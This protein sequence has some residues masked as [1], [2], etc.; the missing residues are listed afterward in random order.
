MYAFI[1]EKA[2][3]IGLR[4]G[5]YG[6]RNTSL[7]SVCNVNVNMDRLVITEGLTRFLNG[8]T[9]FIHVVNTTVIKD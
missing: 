6:G 3:S 7:H 4:S 8:F 5:E 9:Y 1:D 2:C